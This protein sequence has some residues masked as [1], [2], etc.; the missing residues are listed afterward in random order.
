MEH[1]STESRRVL[2]ISYSFPPNMEMG[3]YT[4][5]Q[6]ARYLPLYGWE[7]VVLTVKEKYVDDPRLK[8]DGA[9]RANGS[10]MVI[11]THKLPH[12]SDIYRRF[13]SKIGDLRI[14]DCGLRIADFLRLDRQ[15]EIAKRAER[16]S[17]FSSI[18][19]PQS[20]IRN[21]RG[22][23][24][25]F[26]S[27]PDKYNGWLIPAVAAGL[28]AVIQTRVKLIYSSAPYFTSH[29][30]GYWLALLTGLPWVAHFRDPW[31]TGLRE[32]YRPGNKICFGI[33]RALE[34]MTVSRADAV[35]CVTEEHAALMR[36][37]YDQMAASKFAVV[38]NGFDGLEWQE[39]IES[40]PAAERYAAGAPRK[41]RV[42]YAGNLYMKRNPSPL[43]RALRTL[44]DCGE[45]ARDEVSVELIGSCESSE[46]RGMADL[47]SEAGIGGCVEMT[48]MLSHSETL[49]RLL[50]SD[51]LLLLAEE[52]VVQI[53]G[54]TFEYLKTRRPILALA[55]EG[56][57]AKLLRRTGGAWVVNPNDQ[58]GVINAVRECYRLWKCGQPGPAPDPRIVESFD[59]R[60]TTARIADL[61][62]FLAL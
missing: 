4:C 60:R 55:C 9:D 48:G 13:K 53:P 32:E 39:A 23:L 44:I 3:A 59:R 26:S 24:L 34:R 46:G 22:L 52:L 30:A 21:L 31:V 47:V 61:L 54:K 36:A 51:L 28:R 15:S 49:R 58:P 56:A 37:A 10:D 2:F 33:N 16:N 62:D 1:E 7:P 19:N 38:M 6:I 12:V 41:F 20:A 8:H 43:F 14:A 45:I 57:V 40:L 27:V 35:V 42:T 29:L 18:R 11:R 50:Q 5:A 17:R 25:S